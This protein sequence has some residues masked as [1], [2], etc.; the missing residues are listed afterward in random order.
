MFAA[1]A[2]MEWQVGRDGG[3]LQLFTLIH[4]LWLFSLSLSLSLSL[5]Q[6]GRD[7]GIATNIFE[8]GMEEP[9]LVKE[10]EYILCYHRF[11]CGELLEKLKEGGWKER[12][13]AAAAPLHVTSSPR[14]SLLL[15]INQSLHF[16][17]CIRFWGHG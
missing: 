2:M 14:F 17:I 1:A 12:V 6:V 10:P 11:L 8:K 13:F 16:P 5:S 7:G 4:T 9:R 3:I 15:L